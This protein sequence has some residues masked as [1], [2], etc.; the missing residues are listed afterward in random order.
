MM[1]GINLNPDD[2]A[3][4]LH[5]K[6]RHWCEFKYM[7]NKNIDWPIFMNDPLCISSLP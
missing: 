2:D 6:S 4:F 1:T 5:L 3:Q 7:N